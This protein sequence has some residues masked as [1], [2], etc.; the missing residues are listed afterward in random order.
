MDSRSWLLADNGL[1]I[2]AIE[3]SEILSI[4][5]EKRLH[6]IPFA[7]RHVGGFF[8][9]EDRFVTLFQS[10]EMGFS[11]RG[12][13]I[14]LFEKNGHFLALCVMNVLGFQSAKLN[15]GAG[16]APE[17]PFHGLIEYEGRQV[18]VVDIGEL[19]KQVGLF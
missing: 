19:Y 18:P 2:F 7:S 9:H 14:L 1:T 16:Q 8:I 6:P 3:K 12:K 11:A 13:E 4:V 5:S 17:A 15:G 10:E